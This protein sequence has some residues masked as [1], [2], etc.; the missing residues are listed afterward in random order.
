MRKKNIEEPVDFFGGL[1][2][3]EKQTNKDSIKDKIM[4]ENKIKLIKI[5]YW[6]IDKIEE[7]LRWEL[8]EYLK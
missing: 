5:G 8:K 3:F 1:K 6:Q 4:L 7:A 2:S